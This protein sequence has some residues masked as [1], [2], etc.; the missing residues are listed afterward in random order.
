[1]PEELKVADQ[2]AWGGAMNRIRNHAEEILLHELVYESDAV[3]ESLKNF[4]TATSSQLNMIPP[5]PT[6]SHREK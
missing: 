5:V 6:G 4:G 3:C 1:M 2:M